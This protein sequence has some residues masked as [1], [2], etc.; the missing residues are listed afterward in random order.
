[1]AKTNITQYDSTPSNNA[2]IN[3]INIAENCPASN[4]NNAIRELMAHLKNM[5]TGSQALTSPSFTAMSTDT[6]NE[7][8]INQWSCY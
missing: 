6:I 4:I 2:D 3:S 7:K 1:M 8:N 5:D